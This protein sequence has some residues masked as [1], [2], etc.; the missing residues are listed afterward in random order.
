M[1]RA[2][3]AFVLAAACSLSA[4]GPA[5]AHGQTVR[6][7]A[8]KTCRQLWHRQNIACR[9]VDLQAIESLAIEFRRDEYRAMDAKARRKMQD[10]RVQGALV[11]W[12]R[13]LYA[14]QRLPR[15]TM[16]RKGR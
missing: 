12:G 10:A 13:I 8:L 2:A 15:Q 7:E 1:T 4:G 11:M 16:E 6:Q 14:G 5:A 9:P 3:T